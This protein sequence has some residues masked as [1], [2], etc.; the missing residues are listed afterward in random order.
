LFISLGDGRC[1]ISFWR[2]PYLLLVWGWIYWRLDGVG[3]A[4]RRP[5]FRF[6][7]EGEVPRPLDYFVASFSSV[8]SPTV[9]AIRGNSVRARVLVIVH[10]LMIYNVMGLTFS[11]AVALV[12]AS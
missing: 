1:S 8:L 6:D 10:G 4:A 9:F 2:L 5:L 3:R 12:Q 11:R 7:V